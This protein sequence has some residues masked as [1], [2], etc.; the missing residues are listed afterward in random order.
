MSDE[1][2]AQLDPKAGRL[3]ARGRRALAAGVA[4][5]AA[6]LAAALV[7]ALSGAVW[8][9]LA[10]I[11]GGW[12]QAGSEPGSRVISVG[13]EVD[14]HGWTAARITGVAA[15]PGLRVTRVEGASVTPA[16]PDDPGG[17]G[18]PDSALP[19]T[20]PVHGQVSLTVFYSVVSCAEPAPNPERMRV[21][22]SRWW[23]TASVGLDLGRLPPGPPLAV[24]A[25]RG[26]S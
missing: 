6:L 18:R 20:V 12:Q 21:E 3:T 9:R 16:T 14:N 4:F 15:P 13:V 17:A 2:W 7:V 8:P 1:V 25:C 24:G 26:A 11:G 23:G 19:I 22:V 5:V 10:L